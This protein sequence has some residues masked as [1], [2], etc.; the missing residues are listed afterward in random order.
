[1]TT[2]NQEP[3]NEEI[4]VR[5]YYLWEAA[6]RPDGRD[7]DFWNKAQTELKASKKETS[8][9]TT[10]FNKIADTQPQVS[11]ISTARSAPKKKANSRTPVFA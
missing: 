6:G 8:K 5:A 7:Q 3:T 1:M 2:T 9:P 4:S 11:G 10:S